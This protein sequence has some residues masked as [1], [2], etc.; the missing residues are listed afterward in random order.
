[1]S[2]TLLKEKKYAVSRV[3]GLISQFTYQGKESEVLHL[4]IL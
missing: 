4:L 2:A 1:M 3:L